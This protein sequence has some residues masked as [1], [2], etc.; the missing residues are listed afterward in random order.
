[1][2]G[3]RLDRFTE[4][5][6]RECSPFGDPNEFYKSILLDAKK[7]PPPTVDSK[8]NE[9]EASV[10]TI[11]DAV[12][13]YRVD[14][15]GADYVGINDSGHVVLYPDG[16]EAHKVDLHEIVTGL[17]ERGI[18][19]PVLL[20]FSDIINHRLHAINNAFQVAIRENDYSGN[21]QAVY[22][23]K[24]NQQHQ[25]VEEIAQCGR[26]LGFGME[27]GSKPELLAVMAM[28][29]SNPNQ[30][31]VCNGFKDAQYIEAVILAHKLGRRIVPVI[32][33]IREL[34]R[35]IA[36]SEKYDVRPTIGARVKLATTG[37]GR[38]G[39]S[40]GTKS[41]FGM[42]TTELLRAVESLKQH[43]MIDCLDLLHCHT[44]SQHQDIATIKSAVTELA[45]TFV[46]LRKLDARLSYLDIGGGLGVDY[47]GGRADAASSMNYTLEEY[48]SDVVYRIGSVCDAAGIKPPTIVTECGRAMAAYSSVLVFDVLGSTGPTDIIGPGLG[49]DA[50][51]PELINPD[52]PQPVRDLQSALS[53]VQSPTPHLVACYHDAMRALDEVNTLYSLGYLTLEQRAISE[54]MFWMICQH[55]QIACASLEETPD[56]LSELD[57]LMSDVYFCNFS[58]FQ[59]LPDAW[60]ID[61]F[62]P[63][64][65]ISRLDEEPRR[66]AI[67][68]DITCDS[69]GKI[70]A[71][72]DPESG[73]ASTLSVH[74]LDSENIYYM[75]A[76]LVG[77]Y[78]E[79]LG[80][81]HNL[82]GDA[83]TVHIK[84]DKDGWAIDELI[85]GDTV[86]QVLSYVQY[87]TNELVRALEK[88]CESGVRKGAL[89][90]PEARTMQRFY[91]SG[92]EGY[93]Y[94]DPDI[95]LTY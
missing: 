1:M 23:I 16:Q 34:D 22:P 21:Y 41:K 37:S 36:T 35:I 93:T 69:D 26:G 32:E 73:I 86:R 49:T 56:E 84:L 44:G 3:S 95:E 2:A 29:A 51:V 46:Q 83:H 24:V 13:L 72:I 75:G 62:F 9:S 80:D 74:E 58:I 92:L 77:A 85:R 6:G 94:L 11:A 89:T 19:T 82:F 54:R 47:M 4:L 30:L 18:N 55:I 12:D 81:L 5:F 38:W 39:S 52:A 66:Q 90:V 17:H 78:Q 20:R 14:Q 50:T 76:F 91:E 53:I 57:E 27:V 31:I 59:S 87:N 10:W 61:Q 60:A 65:P 25:I 43:D 45:H 70:G 68:G 7:C 42:T 15:W 71:Y 64:M 8:P 48:A 28:T 79:T 40:T 63:I 88:E 33:N 67:L